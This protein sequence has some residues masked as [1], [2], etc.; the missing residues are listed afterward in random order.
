MVAPMVMA[1][2][3]G[4][5]ASLGGAG[6]GALT[7]RAAP[8][9]SWQIPLQTSHDFDMFNLNQNYN[10]SMYNAQT[11]DARANAE[12]D[13]WR[14]MN[15][16]GEQ[17]VYN[18]EAAASQRAWEEQMAQNSI[19]WRVQDAIRS[20]VSPLVALGAPTFSPA[21]SVVGVGGPSFS[22]APGSPGGALS[23][24]SGLGASGGG[25][26]DNSWMAKMGANIGD[27]A[28]KALTPEDQRAI[29]AG[30]I[31][32]S[33]KIS[34]NDEMLR[35][36]RLDNAIKA[37]GAGIAANPD[38]GKNQ[39]DGQNPALGKMAMEPAKTN[40]IMP[41]QQTV[42][43]GNVNPAVQWVLGNNGIRPTP[44]KASGVSDSDTSS[45][46]YTRWAG[47]YLTGDKR[48]APTPEQ[49]QSLGYPGVKDS[50]WDYG[51]LTWKPVYRA[52]G[53]MNPGNWFPWLGS[54]NVR[55]K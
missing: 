27:I 48:N 14:S 36:I 16:L 45:V 12:T 41:N 33:Q 32:T 8:D 21:P 22:T 54:G 37:K 13:Y 50:S 10:W 30:E 18:R 17:A 6:L 26:I 24:P 42:Q 52:G 20:G 9:T 7:S 46:E 53:N 39:L 34:Y 49:W 23:G 43:S 47:A 55:V 19:G 2:G 25:G 11:N 3:I 38:A 44:S 28:M 5:A 40:T 31:Q 29:A 4:A 35:G 15:Y 1:A 51:T